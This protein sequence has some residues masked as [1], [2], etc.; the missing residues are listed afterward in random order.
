VE[1]L[2]GQGRRHEAARP[3]LTGLSTAPPIGK[4][5]RRDARASGLRYVDV[6]SPGITRQRAGRGFTYRGP[7]GRRI[8]GRTSLERIR[9]IAIPPAWTDVWIC[10]DP[11]GHIQATGRDAA[12]RRQYRYHPAFRAR[13]DAGKFAR[14]V[15]FGERLPRI[16]RRVQR[17]LAR[18][19][20]PRE[21]VLAAVVALLELTR[22][23]VGN[24]EYAALNQS[25]GLSTLRDRHAA[26][27]GASIRFRFRGKGGRVEHRTVIDRRLAA[28]VRRCQDL[29]GQELFQFE[30]EAGEVRPIAS[31]DVNAYLREAAGDTDL[32][33]KDFRT[34]T[35]TLSAFRELRAGPA[36]DQPGSR[37]RNPVLEALQRTADELGNTLAVT[38]GSYVHPA[39]VT[40]F[41]EDPAEPRRGGRT[42]TSRPNRPAS[43]DD[44]LELL[45]LLRTSATARPARVEAPRLARR[46]NRARA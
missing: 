26:V 1:R 39:V 30:D 33:A 13:R 29:P 14:L 44:E 3:L 5:A 37:R 4:A 35:A 24:A 12:G 38:R 43:R 16:R 7:S 17:D 20:L 21:K 40:A 15:R 18:R 28:I 41:E 23:R 31:E 25:F 45:A 11:R 10:P 9:S 2:V 27:R 32:S 22:L 46:S 19:G 36:E 6:E 34:W 42:R 8:G